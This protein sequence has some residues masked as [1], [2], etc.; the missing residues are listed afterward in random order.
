MSRTPATPSGLPPR[1]A[2]SSFDVSEC[3]NR[4]RNM[5]KA[6]IYRTLLSWPTIKKLFVMRERWSGGTGVNLQLSFIRWNS[7]WGMQRRVVFVSR[8]S[9]VRSTF[10][11]WCILGAGSLGFMLRSGFN[12]FV[13]LFRI[14]KA[15]K[16]VWT[17]EGCKESCSEEFMSI[18]ISVFHS[19]GMLCL[20]RIRS[21]LVQC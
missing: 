19:L 14:W 6:V 3:L 13:L 8:Y 10:E 21:D 18:G 2:M 20:A 17:F 12:I 11:C 5:L 7:A 4:P 16:S 9:L 1:K 15:P